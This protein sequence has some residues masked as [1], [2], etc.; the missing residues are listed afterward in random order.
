MNLIMGIDP[1][2]TG[3]IALVD[4]ADPATLVECIDM[5]DLAGAA[6]GTY[7]ADAHVDAWSP[8]TIVAAYIEKV[9]S[10]PA[11]GV[12]SVWTFGT[13]YGTLCGALG[14]LRIPTI[15]VTPQKWQAAQ[16]VVV[17]DVP[18]GAR[19]RYVQKQLSRS[20]A[21]HRWPAHV[22]LFARVKDDGR[23]DACHIAHYGATQGGQ[24]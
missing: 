14:A 20:M 23:S 24:A 15:E 1:G 8:H 7:L 12:R 21:A 17:R 11:Q 10:R 18:A 3:A 9:A 2:R 5:P 19:R 16:G 4:A 13:H 6:L 22:G